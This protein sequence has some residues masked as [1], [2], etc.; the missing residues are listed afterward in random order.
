MAVSPREWIE[1]VSSDL[2]GPDLTMAEVLDVETRNNDAEMS[3][4]VEDTW[5]DR[6]VPGNISHGP[7]TKTCS[8]GGTRVDAPVP[9]VLSAWLNY[10]DS[11]ELR[12]LNETVA[13]VVGRKSGGE[14]RSFI[15]QMNART[16][17]RRGQSIT[18]RR[19]G[20]AP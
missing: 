8:G 9:R 7:R 17:E 4:I 16:S 12:T 18:G 11:N 5:R 20:V 10:F 15:L 1:L 3:A 14:L 13:N 2:L 19:C 6:D